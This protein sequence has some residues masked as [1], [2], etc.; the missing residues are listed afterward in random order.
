MDDHTNDFENLLKRHGEIS[1]SNFILHHYAH[2][3]YSRL[4]NRTNIPVIVLSSFLGVLAQ[5]DLGFEHQNIII[6]LISISAGILKTLDSYFDYTKRSENHKNI[7]VQYQSI[8]SFIQIQLA[9]D[10]S[11]RLPFKDLL[12]IMTNQLDAIRKQEPVI[13]DDIIERYNKKY[14][15]EN[16][17]KPVTVN[18]LTDIQINDSVLI[19][20]KEFIDKKDNKIKI[21]VII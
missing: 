1:E 14:K 16:V 7:S 6:S 17:N 2:Q 4:S 15:D 3:K 10:K 8:S 9:L 19:T 11:K 13:D 5:I 20:P 21:G 12:D 18:G